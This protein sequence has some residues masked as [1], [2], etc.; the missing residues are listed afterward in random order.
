M[1]EPKSYTIEAETP[2]EAD[3]KARAQFER[4]EGRQLTTDETV[5]CRLESLLAIEEA[6]KSTTLENPHD[7]MRLLQAAAKDGASMEEVEAAKRA[8]GHWPTRPALQ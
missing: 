1:F 8:N 2:D 6:P 3:T 5:E 7:R 4:V